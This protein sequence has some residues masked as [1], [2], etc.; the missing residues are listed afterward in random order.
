M[1]SNSI[2]DRIENDLQRAMLKRAF[3]RPESLA[4]VGG[5]ILATILMPGLIPFIPWFIWPIL[6]VI[7]EAVVV[8][9]SLTD[10]AEQQKIIESLYREEINWSDIR[11]RALREKLSE[12]EQ[13]RQR[14]QQVVEQ[15][16]SGV[17]R[18]RLKATT[19]QVY[20]W[21]V[22]M[23]TLA[24]RIDKFRSDPIIQRDLR[25]VPEEIRRLEGRLNLERDPRVREQ[26]QATL[27]SSREQG[28]SLREL[29]GR[30]DRADLQ[31]DHSLASLGT[32][33]SQMLLIGSKDVDSDRTERLR[34]D[35]RDQV[36][37]LHDITET[38][39]EVYDAG[40]SDTL[41]AEAAAIRQQQAG[42]AGKAAQ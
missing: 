34:D 15:Q 20:D 27:V 22:N 23:V 25:T 7:G 12:A 33:Y 2:R 16:R 14:I 30:M 38:L 24:R 8:S 29:K 31:L 4:I 32:V 21:I 41:A 18:D 10:K 11:D 3:L 42:K 9:S 37:A 19:A 26:M 28:D 40:G 5:T 6:G 1:S 39:N 35:I 17:L 13:Y 36:L